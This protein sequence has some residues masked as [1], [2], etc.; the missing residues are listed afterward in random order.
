MSDVSITEHQ[1]HMVITCDNNHQHVIAISTL[2]RWASSL[3]PNE[4]LPECLVRAIARDLVALIEPK[5]DSENDTWVRLGDLPP[6]LVLATQTG[7]LA[8]K[9]EYYHLGG[10]CKCVLLESGEYAAFP[11][12]NDTLVAA[13]ELKDDAII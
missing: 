8:V 10:Q 1:P 7:A 13:V 6:G 12:G 9:T 4:N 5:R 11:N 2:R 3:L